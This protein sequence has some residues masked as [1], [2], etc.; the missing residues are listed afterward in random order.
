MKKK[1]VS[2][3]EE[4]TLY[5][6]LSGKHICLIYHSREDMIDLVVP[7][8]NEGLEK[9]ELCMWV[10]SEPL[11]IEEAEEI[12]SERLRNYKTYREKDQ[13]R[14][15]N[16]ENIYLSSGKFNA[17]TT[18][19]RWAEKEKEALQRGFAGLRVCGDASWIQKD[20]WEDWID[21]EMKV[22][23]QISTLQMTALCTHPFKNVDV[24]NITMLA[25]NHTF[26]FYSKDRKWHIIRNGKL[27]NSLFNIKYFLRE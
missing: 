6:V 11:T 26:A 13:L 16:Y 15:I 2:N 24:T 23:K 22:E 21:Y 8:F 12:L 5:G 1:K 20:I 3:K 25:E 14:I 19:K 4:D 10:I 27:S 7:C 17:E 18:L 9:N